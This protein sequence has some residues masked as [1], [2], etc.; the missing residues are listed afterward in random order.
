MV[1]YEIIG[2]YSD[3][4]ITATFEVVE[5]VKED[6]IFLCGLIKKS[7]VWVKL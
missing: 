7:M 6:T 4:S 5:D 3:K 2:E 1:Q